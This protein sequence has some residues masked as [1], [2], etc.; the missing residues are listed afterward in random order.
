MMTWMTRMSMFDTMDDL[1]LNQIALAVKEAEE[2]FYEMVGLAPDD[3]EPAPAPVR[4]MW[5]GYEPALAAYAVAGMAVL[6]TQHRITSGIR[7][8]ELANTVAD[9]RR[10]DESYLEFETPP[11][12][13]DVDVLR[14]HRSNL[15]R[16]FKHYYWKNTPSD[17]PYIWPV[18]DD[19]GGYSLKLSKYDKA[20][21]ASGERSI[22]KKTLERIDNA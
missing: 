15:Q 1:Q 2:L 10:G 9:L 8:I 5:A 19:A 18:V 7:S 6:T 17:L 20:L 11:W 14:S 21:I 22:P 3:A 4:M 13:N 16:R 12:F